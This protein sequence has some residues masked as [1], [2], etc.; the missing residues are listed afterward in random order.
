MIF[1]GI[2]CRHVLCVA[3][4]LNL[5]S[6]SKKMYL[7]RWCKD[8]TEMEIIHQYKTFYSLQSH[9]AIFS[10]NVIQL[11]QL[12]QDY[13]YNLNR[14]IWRLQRFVNQKP[15]TA[16]IFNESLSILLKAQITATNN[17][18]NANKSSKADNIIRNPQNVKTKGGV[19]SNKRKK[20]SMEISA[21]KTKSKKKVI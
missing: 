6:F 2:I 4:Q 8:P 12:E 3:T 21:Q 19:R 5:D 15:E 20:S 17:E 11:E 13:I 10:E 14:T 1:A 7:P 16:Q 9:S 18:H